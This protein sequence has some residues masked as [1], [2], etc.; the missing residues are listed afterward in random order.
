MAKPAWLWDSFTEA[1]NR[2]GAL[3]DGPGSPN[4]LVNATIVS[5]YFSKHYNCMIQF[6]SKFVSIY[7]N[8]IQIWNDISH[9]HPILY[10]HV[11]S[12]CP[13]VSGWNEIDLISTAASLPPLPS[14]FPFLPTIFHISNHSHNQLLPL[15]RQDCFCVDWKLSDESPPFGVKFRIYQHFT[16]LENLCRL[17]FKSQ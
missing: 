5:K 12:N 4:V 13:I 9:L 15:Q 3:Y 14:L 6:V 7:H 8:C 16:F 2:K 11:A 17:E 10:Q 1:Q